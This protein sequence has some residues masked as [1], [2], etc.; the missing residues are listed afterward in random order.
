MILSCH[1]RTWIYTYV[2]LL[3]FNSKYLN[4]NCFTISLKWRKESSHF[5][6]I[7]GTPKLFLFQKYLIS[8]IDRDSANIRVRYRSSSGRSELF[9]W[10]LLRTAE[11]LS[12]GPVTDR[13]ASNF[14]K[15]IGQKSNIIL[16]LLVMPCPKARFISFLRSCRQKTQYY[17]CRII[18]ERRER[19]LCLQL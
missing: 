14:T 4:E 11:A 6:F 16:L 7:F 3:F 2:S 12:W 5:P 9:S 10:H 8:F 13:D 18:L 15:N 1:H 17:L 19:L